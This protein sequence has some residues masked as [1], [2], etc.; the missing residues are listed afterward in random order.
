MFGP[1]RYI[2]GAGSRQAADQSADSSACVPG[3]A[4]V[5]ILEHDVTKSANATVWRSFRLG[6]DVDELAVR[7]R[8]LGTVFDVQSHAFQRVDH[9]CGINSVA[10]HRVS[11]LERSG[12]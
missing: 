4:D 8:R 5:R 1:A 11:D 12:R 10:H 2:D 6:E 7:H 9:G 3:R